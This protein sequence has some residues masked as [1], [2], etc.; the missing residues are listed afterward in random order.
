VFRAEYADQ[1]LFNLTADPYELVELAGLPEHA[2]TLQM[3]RE[4]MVTQFRAEG[5]GASW[6]SAAGVLQRRTKGQT[7]GAHIMRF[8]RF[9]CFLKVGGAD[10]RCTWLKQLAVL[11]CIY[12]LKRTQRI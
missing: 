6:V 10:M 2:A 3:W 11:A 9:L 8:I 1:Q 4:R 5:R 7:H 12:Q